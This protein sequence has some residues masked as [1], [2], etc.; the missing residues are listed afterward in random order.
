MPKDLEREAFDIEI[1]FRMKKWL[2]SE[3]RLEDLEVELDK[4]R[5]TVYKDPIAGPVFKAPNANSS[6]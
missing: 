6:N 1:R 5:K 2:E 3:G 4:L